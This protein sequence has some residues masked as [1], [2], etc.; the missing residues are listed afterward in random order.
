MLSARLHIAAPAIVIQNLVKFIVYV[1]ALWKSWICLR[2][3]ID[4]IKNIDFALFLFPSKECVESVVNFHNKFH[5]LKMK[6]KQIFIL[7]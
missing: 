4:L 3:H 2:P 1:F 5:I 6:I 7:K